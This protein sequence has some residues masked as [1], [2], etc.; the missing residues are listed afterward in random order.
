[1]HQ[2]GCTFWMHAAKAS[3]VCAALHEA[4]RT[5]CI[6][7]AIVQIIFWLRGRSICT[8]VLR[9]LHFLHSKR[10]VQMDIKSP[11]ILLTR[12]CVAEVA[13]VGLAKVI[14]DRNY[15]T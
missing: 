5:A 14:Q 8:D 2:A 7:A 1:M 15:I 4:Y 3:T 9:G 12:Q 6:D 11:N 13:D 10:I